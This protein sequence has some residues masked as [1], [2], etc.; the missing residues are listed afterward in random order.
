MAGDLPGVLLAP[1]QKRKH[2]RR[3]IARLHFQFT[4]IDRAPVDTRRCT[5]LKPV[6]LKRQF[7]QPLGQRNRSCIAGAAAAVVFQADVDFAAEEGAGRQHDRLGIKIQ[8][9]LG[10]H[11]DHLIALDDQIRDRLL[12]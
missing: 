5:G 10:K 3:I 8:T 12:E 11:A 6:Y 1:P 2:R 7:P 4:E 9:H